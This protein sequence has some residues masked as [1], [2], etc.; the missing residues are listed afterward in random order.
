M[1]EGVAYQSLSESD[2]DD[3][4]RRITNFSAEEAHEI[5]YNQLSY[6]K[7]FIE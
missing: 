3:E 5:L 2:S 7:I 6:T 4:F 1:E